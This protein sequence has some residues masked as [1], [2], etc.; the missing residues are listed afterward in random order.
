[1]REKLHWHARTKI[2]TGLEPE[3]DDVII[4]NLFLVFS[5]LLLVRRFRGWWLLWGRWIWL[6]ISN[7]IMTHISSSFFFYFNFHSI[8]DHFFAFASNIRVYTFTF[9]AY[10]GREIFAPFSFSYDNALLNGL[11]SSVNKKKER[12]YN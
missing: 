2:D 10:K 5:I 11:F 8:L 1:M 7:L 6:W 3:S 9:K 4:L 12:T